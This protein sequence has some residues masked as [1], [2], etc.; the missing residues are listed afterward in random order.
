M[1]LLKTSRPSQ[2]QG[3]RTARE[4]K[5]RAIEQLQARRQVRLSVDLDEDVYRRLKVASLDDRCRT[6]ELVRKAIIEYLDRRG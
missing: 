6:V 3:E 2:V 5:A 4:D 1:A